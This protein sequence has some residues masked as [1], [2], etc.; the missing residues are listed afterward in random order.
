MI[1]YKQFTVGEL[2]DALNEFDENRVIVGLT[3]YV[4]SYRGYYQHV[5]IHPGE[6]TTVGYLI[7]QLRGALG[8]TMHGYKG[9]EYPFNKD[10]LVFVAGYGD[11][12]PGLAG[13]HSIGP[14]LLMPIVIEEVWA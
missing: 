4:E 11:T 9:G 6:E 7:S 10:C 2:I 8:T 5:A 12:G 14:D 13:F 3:D 1:T